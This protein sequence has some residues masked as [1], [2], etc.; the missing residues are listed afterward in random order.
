VKLQSILEELLS[1]ASLLNYTV[2]RE[3]GNFRSGDCRMKQDKYIVLNSLVPLES[4][5]SVLAKVISMHNL[6]LL[7]IKPAVRLI[8]EQEKNRKNQETTIPLDF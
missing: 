6:E 5:I 3:K 7:S 8:I 1:I 4:R 2:R